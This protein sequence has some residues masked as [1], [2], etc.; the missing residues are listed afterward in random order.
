LSIRS[1]ESRR[2]FYHILDE[3]FWRR[4]TGGE[5]DGY[6]TQRFE[7]DFRLVRDKIGRNLR[8]DADFAQL[9]KFEP[10]LA[11]AWGRSPRSISLVAHTA[12]LGYE[13]ATPEDM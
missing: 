5:T 2:G 6:A 7:I 12:P 10:F 13:L 1:A 9:F 4:C 3:N 11:P 8:L